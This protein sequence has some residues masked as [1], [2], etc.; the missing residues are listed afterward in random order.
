MPATPTTLAPAAA[1]REL[2]VDVLGIGIT[3]ATIALAADE[4]ERWIAEGTPDYVCVTGM[5]GVVEAQSDPALRD[6]HN[7]AGMVVPDGMPM[8]WA[9][10]RVG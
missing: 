1:L 5:H 2:K 10:H 4:I 3:P 8:V 9:S 6:V 7:A